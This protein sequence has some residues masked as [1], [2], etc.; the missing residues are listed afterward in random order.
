MVRFTLR[1]MIK[2]SSMRV[3]LDPRDD[4]SELSDIVSECWGTEGFL[5]TN[6]YRIIGEDSSIGMEISDG[7]VVDVIPD[8]R[9]IPTNY[10][11]RP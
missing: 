2:A 1:N 5:M 6:G 10:I 8:P 3:D 7:D 4:V 9:G 11:N